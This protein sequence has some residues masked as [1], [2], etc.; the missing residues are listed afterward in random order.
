[1]VPSDEI[2]FVFHL[3]PRLKFDSGNYELVQV[4]EVPLSIPDAHEASSFAWVVARGI[5]NPSAC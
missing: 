5:F 1:M 4:M 3:Y 2:S